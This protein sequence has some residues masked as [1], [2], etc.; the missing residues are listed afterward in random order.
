MA[1]SFEASNEQL[2]QLIRYGDFMVCTYGL[3]ALTQEDVRKGFY[4]KN[5][6]LVSYAHDP[7]MHSFR[8]PA[9]QLYNQNPSAAEL[10]GLEQQD[11]ESTIEFTSTGSHNNKT[12]PGGIEGERLTMMKLHEDGWESEHVVQFDYATGLYSSCISFA[13]EDG[14]T[15]AED[16][17]TFDIHTCSAI[18]RLLSFLPAIEPMSDQQE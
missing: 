13:A 2:E 10:L 6:I 12:M 5:D 3:G 18:G 17:Y 14:I 9:W 4:F 16:H 7:G 8:T 1:E 11:H 15:D